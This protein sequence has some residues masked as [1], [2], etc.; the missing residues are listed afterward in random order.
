MSKKKTTSATEGAKPQKGK[1][2]AANSAPMPA[3]IGLAGFDFLGYNRQFRQRAGA[4]AD[5]DAVTYGPRVE[6]I[7]VQP[8]QAYWKVIG[9]HHL[10]PDE[11]R[12]RHNAFV[13]A[14]D[15]VG[16]RVKDENLRIGWI[17]EGKADGPAE[18]KRLDKPDDEPAGDVPIEKAMTVTLWLEGGGASERVTGIHTRHEDEQGP[19]GGRSSRFHH[20]YYIVFQRTQRTGGEEDHGGVDQRRELDVVLPVVLPVPS[21]GPPRPNRFASC[22]GPRTPC[23]S[24]SPLV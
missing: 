7:D 10:T 3:A 2:A 5:N 6:A 17:W 11:N 21:E 14:L 4:A 15:E 16:N 19:G 23:V 20:S 22:A 13:A 8:G 24:S 18:S 1:R 9:I 12:D